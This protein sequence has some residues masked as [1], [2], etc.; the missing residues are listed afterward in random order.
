[1]RK[2][3]ECMIGIS[4]IHTYREYLNGFQSRTYPNHQK[5]KLGFIMKNKLQGET[6]LAC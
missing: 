4:G 6:P 5:R 3:R 2:A 1:M